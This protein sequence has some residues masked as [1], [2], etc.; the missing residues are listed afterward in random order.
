VEAQRGFA[1]ANLKVVWAD[2]PAQALAELQRRDMTVLLDCSR[3]ATLQFARDLRAAR[4][5]TVMFALIDTGRPDLATEAVLA[6]LADILVRPMTARRLTNAIEREQ[7]YRAPDETHAPAL[8]GDEVHA[9]SRA[10]RSVAV[11][12]ARAAT[13]GG[14]VLVRGE[15]GTGR[16]IVARAIHAADTSRTADKF[17]IVDCAGSDPNQLAAHLF[18]GKPDDETFV[19]RELECLGRDSL[20]YRTN[21]GTVYFQNVADLP[22]RLQAR[23]ARL[24]RDREAVLSDTGAVVPFDVRG[25]ASADLDVEAA[26]QEGRLRDDLY[27]RLT[28]HTIDIP[29]LR[30]RREDIPVIANH[31]L[32]GIC[33]ARRVSFK[34]LSRPALS[35]ISALPWRGNATELAT[36]LDTI[37]AAGPSGIGLDDVLRHVQLDSGAVF[38]EGGTLRQARAR[39]E[40]QYIVAIL[41]QHRGR[42][43]E[44]ARALG[45]QRTNL[46]R[47]MRDLKVTRK[48][49]PRSSLRA[50]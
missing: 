29:A 5:G 21:G 25:M 47:K 32:R 2:T 48:R 46:Y 34:V 41:E 16:S 23:L 22:T 42:M 37:V 1:G 9:H 49:H 12:I 4:P 17:E 30:N 18:G 15:E 26:V 11:L 27:R 36:L 13:A 31:L 33:A 38:S 50:S 14:G 10:M 35:L 40:R 3:G 43:T 6:G 39:F 19:T 8:P 20:L 7:A 28:T 45:I 24:L 44:A